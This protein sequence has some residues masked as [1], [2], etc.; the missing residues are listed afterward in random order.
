MVVAQ[1]I[2]GSDRREL[3][4]AVEMNRVRSLGRGIPELPS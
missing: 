4:V 3:L 1:Q 2:A